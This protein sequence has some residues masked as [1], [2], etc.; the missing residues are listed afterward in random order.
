MEMLILLGLV[1]FFGIGFVFEVIGFLFRLLFSG[2]GVVLGLIA[3]A[4][5]AILIVPF[6]LSL[7]GFIIP[8]GLL[9]LGVLFLIAMVSNR[10]RRDRRQECQ[11]GRKYY[12]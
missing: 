10:T 11:G 2:L 8:R 3:A 7:V 1:F 9:I 12:Y 6:L 4:V 5:T